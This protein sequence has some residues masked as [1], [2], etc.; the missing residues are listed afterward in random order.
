MA[1][2]DTPL[3]TS[4]Q[5]IPEAWDGESGLG[6][7]FMIF[8]FPNHILSFIHWL[9]ISQPELLIIIRTKAGGE[10]KWPGEN[11]SAKAIS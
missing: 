1:I 8:S 10:A 2:M 4:I 6:A 3:S 5:I 9:R 7:A 11:G